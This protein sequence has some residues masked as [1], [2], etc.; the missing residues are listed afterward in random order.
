MLLLLRRWYLPSLPSPARQSLLLQ[1][2]CKIFT[3]T[4]NSLQKFYKQVFEIP[5]IL[6]IFAFF[7]PNCFLLYFH[8]LPF[9]CKIF[10]SDLNSFTKFSLAIPQ[11]LSIFPS[12]SH[13]VIYNC[14][15][16]YILFHPN[17]VFC[18]SPNKI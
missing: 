18:I 15:L 10:T 14:F 4:L 6:S 17:F 8:N 11:I 1:Q 7:Y 3:S 12:F 13:I 9:F 2:F 5:Q 16:L